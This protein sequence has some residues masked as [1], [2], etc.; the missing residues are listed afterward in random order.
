MDCV[1]LSASSEQNNVIGKFSVQQL[2]VYDILY[3]NYCKKFEVN[4]RHQPDT[5]LA[6]FDEHVYE[7]LGKGVWLCLGNQQKEMSKQSV[8]LTL[9]I[10]F[11]VI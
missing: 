7:S 5:K 4:A 8:Y 3:N 2:A 10:L 1:I 9:K 6:R 11:S